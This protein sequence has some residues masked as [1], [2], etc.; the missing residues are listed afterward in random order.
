[1]EYRFDVVTS[2]RVY[3]C[4]VVRNAPNLRVARLWTEAD[5]PNALKVKRN[6]VYYNNA[7]HNIPTRG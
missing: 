5:F 4:V 2:E 1:M 3:H 6:V 7:R